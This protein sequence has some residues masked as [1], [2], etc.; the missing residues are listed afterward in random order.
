MIVFVRL[1]LLL[2][3]I[4]YC[5]QNDQSYNDSKGM[6]S[7]PRTIQSAG[8]T[9]R[10]A[11]KNLKD[12]MTGSPQ[13]PLQTSGIVSLSASTIE[14]PPQIAQTVPERDALAVADISDG[15]IP[16][17]NVPKVYD[18]RQYVTEIF[19]PVRKDPT[20][21]S[22]IMHEVSMVMLK[23]GCDKTVE[24]SGFTIIKVACSCWGNEI[25]C[26]EVSFYKST[27]S[28]IAG[29]ENDNIINLTRT[30]RDGLTS[31]NKT[32]LLVV[33][34]VNVL[35]AT[36]CVY[37]SVVF[38]TMVYTRLQTR[39]STRNLVDVLILQNGVADFFVGLGV[40]FQSPILYLM[41]SKGSDISNITI[42]T[43]I[44]YI[45]TGV[46]VKMSVFMH[47]VLGVFRCIQIVKPHHK[48]N[49]KALNLCT[50]L[51]MLIWMVIVG[52]D[53]WQRLAGPSFC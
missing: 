2:I 39:R 12:S 11:Q 45:L 19:G 17:T 16:N 29:K 47:C 30:K 20:I 44:S 42:T 26:E 37:L 46:A 6:I 14:Y 35:L 40:L 8:T 50:L 49:E 53:L 23:N 7:T 43:F 31:L 9:H 32:G 28:M 5:V 1:F 41:I 21:T 34:T 13:H 33:T 15:F 22:S 3:T 36:C 27:D 48:I 38:I 24:S 18:T 52:I 10:P 51:Y 4:G 25:P